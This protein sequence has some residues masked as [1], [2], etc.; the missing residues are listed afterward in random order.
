M[1]TITS[2]NAEK[3]CHLV[4]GLSVFQCLF[5]ACIIWRGQCPKYSWFY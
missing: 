5:F 4:C 2:F 1:V 3:C